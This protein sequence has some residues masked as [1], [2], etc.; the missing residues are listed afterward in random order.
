[1]LYCFLLQAILLLVIIVMRKR[2]QLAVALFQEAGRVLENS[3]FILIQPIWT[4]LYQIV[5][6][7]FG[8]LLLILCAGVSKFIACHFLV[9]LAHVF[10]LPYDYYENTMK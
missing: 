2:L 3:P 8:V 1:M 9:N 4:Y 10:M 5:I 6:L 7:A